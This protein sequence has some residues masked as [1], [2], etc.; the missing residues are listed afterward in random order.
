MIH[1]LNKGHIDLFC[2]YCEIFIKDN[3]KDGISGMSFMKIQNNKA[4]YKGHIKDIM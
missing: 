2:I 3:I 1:G 4:S